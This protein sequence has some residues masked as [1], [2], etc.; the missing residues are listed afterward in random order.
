MK[1]AI[2]LLC[3][4]IGLAAG[5]ATAGS[6]SLRAQG[7]RIVRDG[8]PVQLQGIAIGDPLLARGNRPLQDL[9]HIAHD[10]NANVVRISV[11]PGTWREF[12]RRRVLDSL[13][14]H[15]A[16]ARNA[17]L[18]VIITWHAIGIPDGYRQPPPTGLLHDLYDT[19]FPL[20]EDFWEKVAL[21]F[22]EHDHVMFE[23]WNE[24]TW[25]KRADGSHA[26]PQ[27]SVLR[28]YWTRLVTLIRR[29]SDNL[30]IATS[31]GWGYN[32]Q[33]IRDA[34]LADGNVAYAWHVYAG[35][36]GNDALSWR[37]NLDALDSKYPVLV[38]EWGFEPEHKGGQRTPGAQEYVDKF[39]GQF[40]R[41]RAL[42][43]IAWC[44]HPD[45]TPSL[46]KADW[47]TPTAY[48]ELVRALLW[49][50]PATRLVRPE[51]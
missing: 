13:H 42:H 51:P 41:E 50:T 19:S 27:W 26:K 24:P 43:H 16:Q 1:R 34:P 32:L 38:T 2:T 11:H 18:F 22:G 37:R 39:V 9:D 8:T 6:G 5:D 48:G 3:L 23:L 47:R 44:F 30:V 10:W 4:L 29:H 25:P 45:W 35:T 31:N 12:G 33:G 20:A 21:E 36:D 15:V 17:G 14:E 49:E 46:I 28:P 40:L 7:N